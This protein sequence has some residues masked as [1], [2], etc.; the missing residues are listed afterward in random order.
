MDGGWHNR[1]S[2]RRTRRT[3]RSLSS[4]RLAAIL[5]VAVA[6]GGLTG[7]FAIRGARIVSLRNHLQAT[8]VS[9]R[10]ALLEQQALRDRLAQKDDLTA[11]EDAA[12]ERLHWLMPG[13]IRVVFD[14]PDSEETGG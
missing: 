13:E 10:E 9:Q 4:L 2:V 6:I 12:R 11:I 3:E 8:A 14:L 7:L 5:V 1:S